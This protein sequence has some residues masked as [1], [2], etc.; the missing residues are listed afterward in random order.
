MAAVPQMRALHIV[1]QMA[2][3]NDIFW[4]KFMGPLLNG[5]TKE[6]PDQLAKEI[7]PQLEAVL[8]SAPPATM[9]ATASK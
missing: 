4:N 6:T 7:R 1:P 5:E 3:W 2:Q 9:A 8:P